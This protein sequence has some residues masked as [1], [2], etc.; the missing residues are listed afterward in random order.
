MDCHTCHIT[1]AIQQ[2]SLL[3]KDTGEVVEEDAKEMKQGDHAL[4]KMVPCKPLV[5]EAYEDC[6]SLG[7]ITV[8]D[9]NK[10]VATGLI[11]EV[12]Q[13]KSTALKGMKVIK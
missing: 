2:F 4:V 13:R 7:R 1:C 3:D 12:V 6:P 10:I 9:L 8:R 11:K 5:V